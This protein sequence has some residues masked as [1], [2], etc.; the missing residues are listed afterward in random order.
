MRAAAAPPCPLASRLS[1]EIEAL[2]VRKIFSGDD[3]TFV[4]ISRYVNLVLNVFSAGRKVRSPKKHFHI[5]R[6]IY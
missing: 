5:V 1:I 4:G 2:T 3:F 6:A